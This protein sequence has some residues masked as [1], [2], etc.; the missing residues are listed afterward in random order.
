MD[1][2]FNSIHH[3]MDEIEWIE[4]LIVVWELELHKNIYVNEYS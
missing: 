3:Q 4:I 2:N 1:W